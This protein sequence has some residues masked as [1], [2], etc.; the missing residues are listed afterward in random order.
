MSMPLDFHPLNPLVLLG[1]KCLAE[2]LQEFCNTGS[3]DCKSVC[4]ML[5]IQA[6]C[7]NAKSNSKWQLEDWAVCASEN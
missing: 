5:V 6:L 7:Q 1:I 2:A 3:S 4:H